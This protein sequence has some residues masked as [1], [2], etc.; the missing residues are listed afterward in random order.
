MTEDAR[1]EC[2]EFLPHAPEEVWRALTDPDLVARWWAAGDIRPVV[3]HHFSLDMGQWGHQPCTVVAADE[4]RL[5]S[6]RFAEGSLDTTVTWRLVPEGTG[7]R[8]FLTHEG[9]DLDSPLGKTAF[10]GMGSGWPRM[11]TRIDEALI[12]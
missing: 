5:L 4:P 10:D 7:T 2:D 9:F 11:L 6:F 3:G 1:I 12:A 8:L